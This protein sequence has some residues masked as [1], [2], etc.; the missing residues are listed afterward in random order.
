MASFGSKSPLQVIGFR[1]SSEK[2]RVEILHLLC[3]SFGQPV[4]RV[5]VLLRTRRAEPQQDRVA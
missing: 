4:G 3:V 2:H 1:H 5:A